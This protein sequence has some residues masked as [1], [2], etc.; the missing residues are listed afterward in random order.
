MQIGF[1]L[2]FGRVLPKQKLQL[3]PV[4]ERVGFKE[5]PH[6]LFYC[7]ELK[8]LEYRPLCGLSP[9][10]NEYPGE[11]L[12]KQLRKQGLIETKTKQTVLFNY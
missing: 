10:R 8:D 1:C 7:S 11:H 5:Q 2:R 9:S 4:E 6:C 3:V 12:E